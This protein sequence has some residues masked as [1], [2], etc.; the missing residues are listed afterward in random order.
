MASTLIKIDKNGTEYWGN[1]TCQRCGGAGGSDSVG[2]LG[3]TA[4][5]APW[6]PIG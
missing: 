5:S 6:G 4:R 3:P 2:A 1:N